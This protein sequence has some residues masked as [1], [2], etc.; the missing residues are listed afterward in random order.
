M[1]EDIPEEVQEIIYSFLKERELFLTSEISRRSLRISR[2]QLL[3][4]SYSFIQNLMKTPLEN[5]SLSSLLINMHSAYNEACKLEKMFITFKIEFKKLSSDHL[6]NIRKNIINISLDHI[7]EKM[8]TKSVEYD[9]ETQKIMSQFDSSIKTE[10]ISNESRS[11][12]YE[13]VY[14]KMEEQTKKYNA[15]LNKELVF[16]QTRLEELDSKHNV[17]NLQHNKI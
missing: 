3:E 10:G 16:W 17:M 4:K 13:I 7:Q 5:S 14:S 12:L 11:A 9:E 8:R 6:L 15:F 1:L 2:Q